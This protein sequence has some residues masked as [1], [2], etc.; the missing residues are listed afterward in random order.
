[1]RPFLRR[2]RRTYITCL[3][4]FVV[5]L[6]AA[7]TAPAAVVLGVYTQTLAQETGPALD[8]F[9]AETGVM[10]Q[11]A[12]YYQDWN[13]GWS[14]ALINPRIVGPAL[15]RGAVP[16]IT[17]E[18][19]LSNLGTSQPAYSPSQIAAGAFDTYIWRAAREA[20]SFEHPFFLRLA[21]EMNGD[22]SPWGIQP[23]NSPAD[24]VAM[25]RH[26]V[27]IFRAAGATNV[28][29][30]WSPNVSG[31][32]GVEPFQAYYP[33]DAWVDDIGL[34]GYNWGPVKDSPW[35]TFAQIFRPS[36]E[37]LTRL[38]SKPIFITETASTEL[39]G[40]KAA[41]ITGIQAALAS[42]MPRVR[43]LIWFDLSKETNWTVNSS[44][45]SLHAFQ[46]LA[47]SGTFTGN[48]SALLNPI[49]VPTG[50]LSAVRKATKHP[51]HRHRGHT[52]K[53][54]HAQHSHH[55]RNQRSARRRLR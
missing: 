34:D 45:S 44:T 2:A 33:G 14:T 7:P 46:A 10:P 37:A 49:A 13:P 38:T 48:V 43:A 52:F 11:I 25:W 17:W 50:I 23:G 47:Q 42:S 1:M 29:W 16:M 27:S 8:Q 4:P 21:Q 53:R 9:D 40:N 28:R 26:V 36:Y 51:T 19:F 39:G 32:A 15:A 41:W 3:L 55:P 5:M 20:A 6:V 54:R 30:V 22:W 35:L 24:Y 31:F 12:M 18:P